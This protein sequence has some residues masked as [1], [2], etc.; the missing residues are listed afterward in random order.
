MMRILLPFLL[1]LLAGQTKAATIIPVEN[2]KPGE[3]IIPLEK[4]ITITLEKFLTLT[5][6]EYRSLTGKKMGLVKKMR[7]KYSQ[8]LAKKTIR[9]DGTADVAKLK[10]YGFFGG[11]QW[12]W[13]GF[14]LGFL[15]VIG[16]IICLFINDD[17]KW[18]RFW[19]AM[20]VTA[21]IVSIA[22]VLVSAN[23]Y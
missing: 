2:P 19:T 5:P 15:V 8:R 9:Q 20:T 10:K 21:A 4:G 6:K 7:L 22:T 23:G 1:L 18:D 3:V 11:W 16:P 14:A 13:G 12:H 17:Y